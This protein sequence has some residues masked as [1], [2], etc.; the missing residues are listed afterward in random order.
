M[1]KPTLQGLGKA[2][3]DLAKMHIWLVVLSFT[4]GFMN[5]MLTVIIQGSLPVQ[6]PVKLDPTLFGFFSVAY[7]FIWI[8]GIPF[9]KFLTVTMEVFYKTCKSV[10]E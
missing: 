10:K 9:K 6:E 2:F 5:A 7:I 8:A 4:M 1:N 3:D